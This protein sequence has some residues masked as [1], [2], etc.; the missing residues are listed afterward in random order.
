MQAATRA[1]GLEGVIAKRS[2]S[3]YEAGQRSGAW[4][5]IKNQ[6]RQELVIAGWVA[7][8]G[9]RRGGIGALLVGHY[10][11]PPAAGGQKPRLV[12]A[13]KVGTG[14]S[15]RQLA[16]LRARLAPLGRDTSP[17]EIGLPAKGAHFAEPQLVGE[18]TF[19][20]WTPHGTLRHPSFKGLRPD[21]RAAE[22]V[23]EPTP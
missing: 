6:R 12:Y 4:L 3:L 22:V 17:F 9:R 1:I 13:G 16:E 8:E 19:T 14:F 18:F 2:G 15:D 21:K 5:K 23:R 10:D 7:G 11:R 20:E